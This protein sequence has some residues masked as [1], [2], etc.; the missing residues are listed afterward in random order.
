MKTATEG[1]GPTCGEV[2]GTQELTIELSGTLAEKQIDF[3]ELDLGGYGGTTV[4]ARTELDGQP[5]GTPR[6]SR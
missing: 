6:R 5:V 2:N 4:R 1:T 3:G